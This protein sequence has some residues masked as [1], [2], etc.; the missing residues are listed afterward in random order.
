MTTGHDHHGGVLLE[1][2]ERRWQLSHT[3]L[4]AAVAI[5]VLALVGLMVWWPRGEGPVLNPGGTPLRYVD[6]IVQSVTIEECPGLEASGALTDCQRVTAATA[7]GDTARFT[8]FATD[9]DKPTLVAGDRVV[10]AR[11]PF[12]PSEYR[13]SFSDFQRTQ[14]LLLL[15]VLFVV[16]VVLFGRWQGVRALA[17]IVVSFV[18][19]LAFLL[20]SLLRGNPALPVALVATVI[21]AFLALYLAHGVRLTTTV[22]L[23]GTLASLAV[24]AVLGQA[25]VGFTR[26]TGL[27][28]E[29]A[30]ILRI[31]AEAVDLR[32]LLVAGIVVGAL[33]VLDDVTVT[34]VSAVVQLRRANPSMSRVELY[35]S[36]LKIGRD[37]IASTVNTLVLAYAGASLPILLL[38]AE[39]GQPWARVTAGE[40]VAMEIVRTLVGSIGL[41]V[42]VPI[43]TAL[44]AVLL[45]PRP[46]ATTAAA[47][48]SGATT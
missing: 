48:T 6:A 18:V 22:A 5:G 28:G 45:S 35:R 24:I 17:G 12:A 21:I 40:L 32:G 16:A 20:P 7:D 30:Q 15:G 44:A 39:A 33:G 23:V 19:L 3:V 25:F 41:I 2:P 31:T 10:L 1:L 29:E 26:L 11:N 36:A 34:Q 38:Y 8:I 9:F 47:T 43:T 42:A 27:T 13:Y 4:T 14:P 37:H 46:T